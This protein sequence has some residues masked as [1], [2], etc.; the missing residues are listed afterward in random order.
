MRLNRAETPYS[1]L[2][3]QSQKGQLF[4]PLV[5]GQLIA[6]LSMGLLSSLLRG[7]TMANTPAHLAQ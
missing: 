3:G 6:A 7:L 1:N 4:L 2:A 5:T